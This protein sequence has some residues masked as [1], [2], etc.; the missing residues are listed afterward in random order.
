MYV[1]VY[2]NP[3]DGFRIRGLFKSS[4]AA[5]EYAR[6]NNWDEM[7]DSWWVMEVEKV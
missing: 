2:G 1:L 5:A 7:T 3:G 4:L 6:A